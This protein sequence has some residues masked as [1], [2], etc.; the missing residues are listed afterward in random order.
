MQQ[1]EKI[2]QEN[3]NCARVGERVR[4]LPYSKKHRQPLKKRII[5]PTQN[6]CYRGIVE[7]GQYKVKIDQ[8]RE[9]KY[10]E[11]MGCYAGEYFAPKRN[12]RYSTKSDGNNTQ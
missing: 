2:K 10:V 1:S 11:E 3:K 4:F 9:K 8:R 5:P 7:F 6:R 12:R